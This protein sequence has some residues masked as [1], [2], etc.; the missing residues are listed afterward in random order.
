MKPMFIE[1]KSHIDNTSTLINL[2]SIQTIENDEDGIPTI[3][4]CSERI[5]YTKESFL[6]IKELINKVMMENKNEI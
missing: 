1:L 5:F 3:I 4:M 6:E 2:N